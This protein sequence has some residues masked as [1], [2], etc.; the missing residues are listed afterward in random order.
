MLRFEDAR[1]LGSAY[2]MYKWIYHWTWGYITSRTVY[3]Y[4]HEDRLYYM[5]LLV[6]RET[7]NIPASAVYMHGFNRRC[8]MFK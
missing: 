1:E 7:P 4:Y 6:G 8:F 2:V 3:G 5:K